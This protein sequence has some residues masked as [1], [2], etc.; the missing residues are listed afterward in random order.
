MDLSKYGTQITLGIAFFILFA[1][2]S[3]LGVNGLRRKN[4]LN[5]LDQYHD[6]NSTLKALPVQY[7]LNKVALMPKSKELEL[8]YENWDKIYNKLA[9]EE[10][11]AIKEALNSA[12]QV[13]Y[14]RKF[15][16][17]SNELREIE[18]IL[19]RHEN[20]YENLLSD[21]TNA[22]QVDV[23]N[24]EEIV[25]QKE[26]YRN[27]NKMFQANFDTYK[28][29]N[30]TVERYLNKIEAT[31]SDIDGLLNNSEVER[32]RNLGATLEG[33]LLKMK[34]ILSSLPQ[35]I[36]SLS[37]DLPT[38]LVEVEN[39]YN[40]LLKKNGTAAHLDVPERLQK[41]NKT[42][43]T[44]LSRNNEIFLKDLHEAKEEAQK[45]LQKARE[46][47]E[48]EVAANDQL[49]HSI[50]ELVN[51]FIELDAR[52]NYAN[53]ELADV[54]ERYVLTENEVANMKMQNELVD[55]FIIKKNEIVALHE[56]NTEQ[57]SLIQKHIDQLLPKARSVNAAI[58]AYTKRMEEIRSDEK[59]IKDEYD[60][61]SYIIKDCEASL[62]DMRLPML[63]SAYNDTIQEAKI[64]LKRVAEELAN[65]PLNIEDLLQELGETRENVYKLYDNS[66]NLLKTAQMAEN[67]II[68][69]NRYRL[70]RPEINK[71][72]GRAEA[73]FNSGEYTKAL[74]TAIEAAE[75][76]YP[77]IRKEL[78]QYKT[79]QLK[80]APIY[81]K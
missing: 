33:D 23:K 19:N 41:V 50:K 69:A 25:N 73:F 18:V 15:T 37:K 7:L 30:H 58:D 10:S 4:R 59:R 81:V 51:D 66:R 24:R 1:L 11:V 27:F 17:A 2:M 8:Q 48:I 56:N 71:M 44:A 38:E 28:P 54:K 52:R 65:K 13:I 80:N 34:D 12:E 60:N 67:T 22:T 36:T 46:E 39:L 9:N 43:V 62:R 78:L 6:R 40:R 55:E 79:N 74:S 3:V 42:I 16:Q 31:F 68:F 45:V 64:S 26:L 57:A 21:L 35:L 77:R 76:I 49:D 29:F 61:M 14:A 20:E 75:L 53:K 5:I 72:L 32:A 47:L 63:S 70:K